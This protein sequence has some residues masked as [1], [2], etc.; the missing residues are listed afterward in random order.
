[1]TTLPTAAPVNEQERLTIIDSLRGI[2]IL[3]ILLMNIPGFGLP[4]PVY[5]DL[6]VWNETGINFNVWYFIEM[7]A[8]GTQRALFSILF[9]AG[10][11]LFIGKKENSLGG[12]MPAEYFFR[13]QLWLL[14]FGLFNAFVLL[15]FWDILFQYAIAGMVLFAFRRLTPKA[16][17]IAAV[18][19]LFFQMT[20]DNV[21][22]HRAKHVITKGEH[23]AKQDT[24][25]VKLT[26]AE[27]EIVGEWKD[28]KEK[29][30]LEAKKKKAETGVRKMTAD[31]A[32][33]YKYQSQRSYE[34]ELDYTY[35]GIWD[36]LIF[37]FLGMAFFKNGIILGTAETKV[38]WLLCIGG[39]ALGGLLTWFRLQTLIDFNFNRF[40]LTKNVSIELYELARTIRSIGIFG[41]IMLLYKS[42]AFNW[43]F[44]LL[45][46]VGQMAF[47][48]YLTQSLM[49]GLFFYGGIGFGMFGK[50][51]RY[52]LYYVVG[53]V[54]VIQIIWSHVWLR[55]FKFGPLEWIWRS[56]T[57]WKIQ[58][59]K[60]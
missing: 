31:Y 53:M 43:L 22:L 55:Y 10:I 44:A 6:S 46:P 21:D 28:F 41:L 30:S 23:L 19:C 7:T 8:A 40:E 15:W 25:T 13:R 49:M 56:L 50:L 36:I 26:E 11:I 48:N 14:A 54:W 37:M 33:L 3:G 42:N 24:T 4:S 17:I 1:M 27:K 12:L 29:T 45:R 16:L 18:V 60:R 34:D 57:Y 20:R 5:G 39:L 51:Q 9:G 52:E 35:N 59:M 58:P 47:T 38:Y 2:A 32:T